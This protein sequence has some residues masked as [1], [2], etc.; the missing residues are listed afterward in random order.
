MSRPPNVFGQNLQEGQKRWSSDQKLI[1]EFSITNEQPAQSTL[2]IQHNNQYPF[3]NLYL[4]TTL[5][6]PTGDIKQ[7]TLEILLAE[8]NGRWLGN[9]Y[10]NSKTIHLELPLQAKEKGSYRLEIQQGMRPEKLQ[11]LEKIAFSIT[12]L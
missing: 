9:G 3:R 1:F 5:T 6:L 4:F 12:Q 11:G 7:D 10:G 8:P 2:H